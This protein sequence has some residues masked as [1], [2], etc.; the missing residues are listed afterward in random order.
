ME[1]IYEDNHIIA[2]NKTCGEIVQ[3]DKTGDKPLPDLL[4]AWLKEKYAKPGNVFVGVTHRLDRP[5]SGV[6]LFAKTTKSLARLNEMFRLG[7]VKKTYWAIVKN[8][9]PATEGELVNWLVRNE[10]Q[11]KSYACDTEKPDS[12]KAVLHYKLI[13]RSENYCLLEIDLKT[14]RHHQIRAQLAKA[15]CPIKG[16]LKYGFDR[17]NKDG[18]ISLHARKAEFIHPVSKQLV[19]ITAVV[20]ADTL[21]K[22]LSEHVGVK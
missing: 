4:K 20:P 21:W 12:K 8:S 18:G 19:A 22:A 13:A 2:V 17:S 14:G 1:I 16:D 5:V 11:N 7:E 15:G 9:P 6:V 10:K 3:G